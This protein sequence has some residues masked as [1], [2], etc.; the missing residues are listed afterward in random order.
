MRVLVLEQVAGDD[1]VYRFARGR[2]WINRMGTLAEESF[3]PGMRGFD[4]VFF[5]GK[6]CTT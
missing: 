3:Y 2:Y 4:F 6:R 5:G 1:D